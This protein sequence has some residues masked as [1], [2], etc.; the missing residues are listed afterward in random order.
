MARRISGVGWVTVSLRKSI[1]CIWCNYSRIQRAAHG[2]AAGGLQ[3][4]SEDLAIEEEEGAERLILR[5]SRDVFFHCQVSEEG[6]D[7]GSA[8][9]PGVTF[10]VEENE[11]PDPIHVGLLGAER[12]VFATDGVTNLVKELTGL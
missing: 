4:N 12:G 11:A 2:Q 1:V 6:P 7:F 3:L 10:A 9:V 8:H 5:G